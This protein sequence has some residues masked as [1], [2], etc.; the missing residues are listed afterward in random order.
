MQAS[1]MV[2]DILQVPLTKK[3]QRSQTVHNYIN[4][5]ADFYD[6]FQVQA[7]C[8]QSFYPKQVQRHIQK[9]KNQNP[10]RIVVGM[11]AP[12]YNFQSQLN[13]NGGKSEKTVPKQ[14]KAVAKM[15]MLSKFQS[16]LMQ[17]VLQKIDRRS[18]PIRKQTKIVQESLAK[19][20]IF[21]D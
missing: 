1:G 7:N 2:G 4:Y 17:V 5:L 14:N 3:Q 20:K 8:L 15:R 6:G 12:Q 9:K 11:R 18:K 13:S 21:L 10:E 19:K 16:T